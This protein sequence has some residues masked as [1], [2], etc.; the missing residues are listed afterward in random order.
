MT[1]L[2]SDA[3]K[4]SSYLIA[5]LLV[6]GATAATGQGYFN[7][8][9]NMA[10]PLGNTNDFISQ[11]SWRGY[12]VEAGGFVNSHIS[13]GGSFSW[14]GFYEAFPYQTYSSGTISVSGNLWRY[15]NLY[16]L[17]VTG[18]Y[19]FITEKKF[20]P[21]AGI[22]IGTVSANKLSELGVLTVQDHSWL[23]GFYSEAGLTYWFNATTGILL[24][25]RYLISSTSQN[26]PSQSSL[27]LNLGLV[28][29]FG[30]DEVNF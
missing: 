16:P 3:M 10:F 25:A 18:K 14:E 30:K 24:D 22:G 12:T 15:I 28:W 17:V 7:L 8:T 6:L 11:T 9:Y 20:R 4:R 29:S 26:I 13:I 1:H 2:C 23:F 27:G 5:C 21:Y 19:Y